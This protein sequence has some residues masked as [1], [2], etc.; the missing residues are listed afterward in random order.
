MGWFRRKPRRS[1]PV[2][3]PAVSCPDLE[4][5]RE[6]LNAEIKEADRRVDQMLERLRARE[7]CAE[8]AK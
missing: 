3:L 5:V 4:A 6:Q 1:P 8:P 7:A 2:A